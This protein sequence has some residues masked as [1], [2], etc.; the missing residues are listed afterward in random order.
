MSKHTNPSADN[1]FRSKYLALTVS[2][3]APGLEFFCVDSLGQGKVDRNTLLTPQSSES[4]FVLKANAGRFEYRVRDSDKEPA[5][6][7]DC[8]ESEIRLTSRF[9]P[10]AT[11]P[12]RLHFDQKNSFATVLGL[13]EPGKQE[14]GLPAV[15]H[16]PDKGS[17][18][19][20]CSDPEARLPYDASRDG[21]A[22]PF[23]DVQFPAATEARPL[24]EYDL[25]VAAIYPKPEGLDD[26][27]LFDG[28]KRGYLNIFQ[29]NPRFQMLANN[30]AS[31]I[32]PFTVF[33]YA[34]VAKAA[35]NMT[36]AEQRGKRLT[37]WDL[38]RMT[39]DRYLAGQ[40]GYGQPGYGPN[41]ASPWV[42]LDVYPSLLIAA[43]DYAEGTK[44]RAWERA[45][46]EKLADWGRLMFAMDTDGDGLLKYPGTGN[47]GDRPTPRKRPSNW[48]DTIAFGHEDA[49]SNALAYRAGTMLA[50]LAHHLGHSGDAWYFSERAEKL[51]KAFVPTF[52]DH[53]TG[54]L[55][56]WR[57]A[58]GKLH[59]Y[60][61][62]FINGIAVTYGLVPKDLGKKIMTRMMDKFQ[63]V[64]YDRF[65]LGL[66]G[67]LVAVRKE[68]YVK[69]SAGAY[70]GW[71]QRFGEPNL[72]DGS[73]GF[74]FY[75]NGG[76]TACWA[77]Y[78][79]KALYDLGMVDQ[80]R[81]VYYPMLKSFADGG[82]SGFDSQGYSYDWRDWKGGAHGYE[83]LLTDGYL[84]LLG[85]FD[86]LKS[87][88]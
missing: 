65:D 20:T 49:W 85:V 55:A 35:G 59:D 32:V 5:W 67:N 77:Y 18:R 46:Y 56:G 17:L 64:G 74:Q 16:L 84:T 50:G 76:A 86:E 33:E 14:V 70:Q 37:C 7:I 44:D 57:S 34:E 22:P 75:E 40:K 11:Q 69:H 23:V 29:V 79:V 72:D 48:W 60:W 1:E 36:L 82:F 25:K 26:D 12:F 71:E 87:R 3:D 42:F 24:V 28:F 43:C 19:I 62:T 2:R 45:N 58:D 39:L 10:E 21:P 13:M 80:A 73:D 61:F 41:D 47:S 51:R 31:D 53:R 83:G 4:R 78:T 6:A 88:R 30:S 8:S 81:K 66:P 27:P 52:L 68:D 54:V 15:L 9:S 38:I 63:E